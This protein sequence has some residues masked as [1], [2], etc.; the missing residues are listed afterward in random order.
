M[1]LWLKLLAPVGLTALVPER[2]DNLGGMV[3]AAASPV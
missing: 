2:A 3:A 1:E